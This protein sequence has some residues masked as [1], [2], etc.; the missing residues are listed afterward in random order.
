MPV[1]FNEPISFTQRLCEDLEYSHVLDRAAV[2]E[3]RAT[4]LALVTAF[5]MSPFATGVSFRTGKPFNP[6][7]AETFELD[8]TAE[9]GWR[10]VVEQVSHHPPITAMHCESE[11]WTYWQEWEGKSKFRGKYL[12]VIPVGLCHVVLKATGDHYTFT[13]GPTMIH[14]IIVGKLW[15]DQHGEMTITN[16][17]TKQTCTMEFIP[18][19]YFSSAEPRQVK[20]KVK[21]ATGA[22][23]RTLSGTWDKELCM[24]PHP[25][26][27]S[28]TVL[29]TRTPALE[30]VQK[31]FGFTVFSCT[32]NEMTVSD[33]GCASTDARFRLDKNLMEQGRWDD[34]NR[35]KVVFEESQR[36][37]R[38]QMEASKEIWEPIWFRKQQDDKVQGRLMHVYKGGYWEAK[39]SGKW[40]ERL[41][42]LYATGDGGLT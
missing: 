2:T 40:P 7:L 24:D 21:S 39:E 14:N 31:M 29:W 10:A 9:Q 11:H 3:D 23:M 26:S 25:G 35:I 36:G 37:R 13:K 15:I 34:A 6:L 38:R 12:E 5:A 16:H 30:N 22:V 20:A 8:R 17:T 28:P 18:Y 33:K 4:R 32:L 41:P 19:S 1:N 27:A 42:D